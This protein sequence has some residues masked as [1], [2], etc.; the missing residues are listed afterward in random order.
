M[1]EK[2]EIPLRSHICYVVML[3]VCLSFVC[4]AAETVPI[5][6]G[7]R[8][9]IDGNII[10][11][12][13]NSYP[14]IKYNDITYL[15]LTWDNCRILGL[16]SSFSSHDG[17][18]LHKVNIT[19]A[20]YHFTPEYLNFDFPGLEPKA[21]IITYPLYLNGRPIDQEASF[22]WLSYRDVTYMPLTSQL[23]NERF[24]W[25]LYWEEASGLTLT[26]AT[27]SPNTNHLLTLLSDYLLRE[28]FLTAY[29]NE[30]GLSYWLQGE[31]RI[32]LRSNEEDNNYLVDVRLESDT[33][34]WFSGKELLAEYTW[35]FAADFNHS[36]L[37]KQSGGQK[38]EYEADVSFA[39]HPLGKW[40]PWFLREL[41]SLQSLKWQVVVPESCYRLV[42]PAYGGNNSFNFIEIQLNPDGDSLH[43]VT[44]VGWV[45]DNREKEFTL[46]IKIEAAR[47]TL[48]RSWSSIAE[49]RFLSPIPLKDGGIIVLSNDGNVAKLNRRGEQMWRFLASPQLIGCL[50]D[51]E[52]N[53]YFWSYQDLWCIDRYGSLRWQKQVGVQSLVADGNYLLMSRRIGESLR[54]SVWRASQGEQIFELDASIKQAAWLD[55]KLIVLG[56]TVLTCLNP[57]GSIIWE[58]VLPRLS[59]K[60]IP[61]LL[62]EY[63]YALITAREGKIILHQRY[64][65]SNK[66][67]IF[68]GDG[69]E[70]GLLEGLNSSS[71]AEP[72]G[73]GIYFL[74]N[75]SLFWWQPGQEL[76]ELQQNI[77]SNSMTYAS[78]GAY[79][80]VAEN[81]AYWAF[82]QYVHGN[83]GIYWQRL[84]EN[85]QAATRFSLQLTEE[86]VVMADNSLLT[87]YNI[88]GE[89]RYQQ[90]LSSIATQVIAMTNGQLIIWHEKDI[91]LLRDDGAILFKYSIA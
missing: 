27:T 33:V 65:Q 8:L 15:P 34:F 38:K 69:Y 12:K 46:S 30:E 7:G 73:A 82:L 44:L 48:Q 79:A 76:Q 75:G 68:D 24:G 70:I 2:G 19:N 25:Q 40:L 29:Y 28:G 49:T 51:E 62:N 42:L 89:M 14:L 32:D 74:S 20:P 35:T 50:L 21:G 66:I 83:K 23:V 72:Y 41:N 80:N 64:L 36:P 85:P 6:I 78:E 45:A 67:M 86:M 22:P 11:S 63:Q 9:K 57:A 87:V 56:E 3:V 10:S 31:Q 71:Q 13:I 55:Q 18:R 1:S 5:E 84:L 43:E 26:R 58:Q 60:A 37:F 88:Q 39:E 4:Q 81:N 17:L 59:T 61:S 54:W 16:S 47:S 90:W 52:E 77:I 53:L 91:M